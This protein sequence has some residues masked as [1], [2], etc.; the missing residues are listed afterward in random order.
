M[1]ERFSASFKVSNTARY[2]KKHYHSSHYTASN[3]QIF[4][5]S[6][7][8]TALISSVTKSYPIYLSS[9]PEM[10]SLALKRLISLLHFSSTTKAIPPW[11]SHSCEWVPSFQ[12]SRIFKLW[13]VNSET[14]HKMSIPI[15]S[16][17]NPHPD[18]F[19]S[20]KDINFPNHKAKSQSLNYSYPNEASHPSRISW[21]SPEFNSYLYSVLRVYEDQPEKKT[22]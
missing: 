22:T 7:F 3:L 11:L 18:R 17:Y 8:L 2:N 5:S 9:V 15:S 20:T 4:H 19:W 12:S 21:S 1:L 6:P 14:A 16:Q 13:L 10:I